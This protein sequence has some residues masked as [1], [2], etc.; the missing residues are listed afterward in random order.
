MSEPDDSIKKD[1][2]RRLVKLGDMMGD[3]LHYEPGGSWITKEYRRA[4]KE[5]GIMPVKTRN[6]SRINE[7]MTERIKKVTCSCGGKLKQTRKG[8]FRAKCIECGL[9]WQ[10]GRKRKHDKEGM[11]R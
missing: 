9:V 7:F 11:E 8:S 3:G 6:T 1:A 4:L 2:L 10:L 5:A